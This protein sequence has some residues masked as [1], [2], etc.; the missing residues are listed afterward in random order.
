MP[1]FEAV[2]LFMGANAYKQA[3]KQ[4][5]KGLNAFK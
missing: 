1:S 2:D 4:A 5:F 3:S